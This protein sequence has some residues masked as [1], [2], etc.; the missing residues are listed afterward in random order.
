VLTSLYV[1]NDHILSLLVLI[2]YSPFVLE[3]IVHLA[4]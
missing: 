2:G 3:G 4:Y 1:P